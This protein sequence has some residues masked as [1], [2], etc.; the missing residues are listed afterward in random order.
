MV[1][2]RI[3]VKALYVEIPSKGEPVKIEHHRHEPLLIE[4]DAIG[5]VDSDQAVTALLAQDH[6][7]MPAANQRCSVL[8]DT[9]ES[10]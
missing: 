4:I 8:V 7:G 1:P 3:I 5:F 6:S 2:H 10:H 9:S